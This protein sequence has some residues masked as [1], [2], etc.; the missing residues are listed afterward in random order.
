MN[1]QNLIQKRKR[2][3]EEYL[4]CLFPSQATKKLIEFTKVDD[5]ITKEQYKF[6]SL[7]IKNDTRKVRE[8]NIEKIISRKNVANLQDNS[9]VW[10]F[11]YIY[12]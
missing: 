1:I 11:S 6:I 5:L 12:W 10:D 9:I 4:Q 8:S 2:L 7:F 3:R